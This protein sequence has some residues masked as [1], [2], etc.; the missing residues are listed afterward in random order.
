MRALP[1]EADSGG[2]MEELLQIDGVDDD[3]TEDM[4]EDVIVAKTAER[5][6]VVST[7]AEI[8]VEI[9]QPA[10]TV[11][12]P[13]PPRPRPIPIWRPPLQTVPPL[14]TNILAT[15]T[16]DGTAPTPT[17]TMSVF[18]QLLT[19]L[20]SATP[21]LTILKPFVADFPQT[22]STHSIADHLDDDEFAL[23]E[24][25]VAADPPSSPSQTEPAP[26]DGAKDIPDFNIWSS[27][28]CQGFKWLVGGTES[29]GNWRTLVRTFL[30][31]RDIGGTSIS[32][33]RLKYNGIDRRLMYSIYRFS[34]MLSLRPVKR[35]QSG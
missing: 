23:I 20:G 16:S 3:V 19:T 35:V 29:W 2:D 31:F 28:D 12:V 10:E 13:N 21:S 30:N 18:G 4:I 25:W 17:P 32:V 8:P 1:R 15:S 26:D 7:A 24:P 34:V 27:S 6:K 5:G 22:P 33:R 14:A 11:V 9:P